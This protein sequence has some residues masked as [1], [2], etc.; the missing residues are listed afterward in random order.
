MGYV[1]PLLGVAVILV[2]GDSVAYSGLE[3]L[4]GTVL[5]AAG[6]RL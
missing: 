2:E 5:V 6:Q 4:R 1:T 3:Q